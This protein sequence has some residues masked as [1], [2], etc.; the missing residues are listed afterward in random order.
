MPMPRNKPEDIWKN[1]SNYGDPSKCWE[2]Q[3]N[4]A[5]GYGQITI[6]FRKWRVHRLAYLLTKGDPGDLFVCHSCDNKLCC[7]P[8]HLWLGTNDDNMKDM[9]VKGR[10]ARNVGE[11]NGSAKLTYDQRNEILS[12][13]DKISQ[14]KIADMF[15]VSNQHISRIMNG[16]RRAE[17]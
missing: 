11:K 5:R 3:G 6:Y 4:V 7:N 8:D 1:V 17:G 12:L 9:V 13:R 14:H 10:S 16:Q 15:G 2:W